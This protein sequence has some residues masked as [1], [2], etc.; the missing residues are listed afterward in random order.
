MNRISSHSVFQLQWWNKVQRLCK[1]DL[2]FSWIPFL[3]SVEFKQRQ[4]DIPL[5]WE[6]YDRAEEWL[7]PSM[8]DFGH[9]L[10]WYHLV[11]LFYCGNTE[12]QKIRT[13]DGTFFLSRWFSALLAF[14]LVIHTNQKCRNKNS[15]LPTI[16]F[17]LFTKHRNY[18]YGIIH[19]KYLRT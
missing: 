2:S 16:L 1:T 9:L 19:I 13:A 18:F 17:L 12:P 11:Y 5:F 8:Y 4:P 6:G 10:Y 15:S 3:S 7:S 14:P